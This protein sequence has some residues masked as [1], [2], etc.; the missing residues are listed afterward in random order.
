MTLSTMKLLTNGKRMKAKQY[1]SPKIT[2]R[3]TQ[4]S[5]NFYFLNNWVSQTIFD[6]HNH[7]LMESVK[8]LQARFMK[9]I[10]QKNRDK[11]LNER[12]G[13]NNPFLY[14]NNPTLLDL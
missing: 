4:N 12:R 1:K 7:I 8:S 13:L 10:R 9:D 3:N 14:Q 6:L 11:W 5:E 2:L